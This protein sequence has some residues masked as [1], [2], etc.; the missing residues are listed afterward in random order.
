VL[1][2]VRSNTDETQ[3]GAAR[4]FTF[5]RDRLLAGEL[6]AGD[7]LL[8]ER[9]LA[10]ALG[11]SRPV[12]REALR[13]L[14]M[15]GLLD[16]QHGR[17]AFV[18]AADASVLGQ[19]LTLCLAPEPNILDDVLQARIAIECQAIR[20]ACERASERDLQGIAGTLDTLVDSLD[21]PERGGPADYAFHFAIVRASSSGS[22]MKIY[23]AI[24]PL[25]MRSHVERRRDTFREPA[26]TAHLVD[27]HREVFLSLARRDPDAA[28][29]RLRE[30]FLIGDDLRRKNLI[31]T[32]QP[33]HH[34]PQ[35]EHS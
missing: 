20:L 17:G 31:S 32:Y 19:A 12:L 35:G 26:I 2:I 6:K 16:I 15:L 9:E 8:A 30:H 29:R 7:R 11:V 23:E 24:S 13:S 34:Q 3:S 18:R 25:L 21:D 33:P 4:V 22:L 10:L 14:A 5:F 1:D 27:A 28:E